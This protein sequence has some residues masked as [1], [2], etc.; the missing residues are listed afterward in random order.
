LPPRARG[1]C[2]L[3]I[4]RKRRAWRAFNGQ[5]ETMRRLPLWLMLVTGCATTAESNR[6]YIAENAGE[7][8]QA[9]VET[10]AQ[11][12]ATPVRPSA[13]RAAEPPQERPGLATSW[14][15]SRASHVREVSFQ[16]ADDDVPLSVGTLFYNDRAGIDAMAAQALRAAL[17]DAAVPMAGG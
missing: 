13:P 5:E 10:T 12:S 14:G 9:S 7:E 16:R 2:Q 1:R 8:I 4:A 17:L 11:T 6:P 3:P 15:E